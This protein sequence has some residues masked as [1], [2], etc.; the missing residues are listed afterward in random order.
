SFKNKN[1]FRLET[2]LNMLERY[3]VTEGS[4]EN[5]NITIISGLPNE[6]TNQK[7]RSEKLLNDNKK[8][9]SMVQ[10]FRNEYCRRIFISE[11][12]GFHGE[13]PCL[14]C[15]NCSVNYFPS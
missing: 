9:L 10:Y 12:F 14:N 1:D 5:K 13:K 11:Y 7:H 4:V 6:L 3:N 2:A 8:L 15:D